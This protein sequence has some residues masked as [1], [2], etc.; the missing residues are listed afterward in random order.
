VLCAF[1]DE[2]YRMFLLAHLNESYHFGKVGNDERII[3]N[4]MLTKWD[5]GCGMD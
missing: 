3:L 4:C 2:K 5:K 1:V